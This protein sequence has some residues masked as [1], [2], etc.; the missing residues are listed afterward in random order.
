MLNKLRQAE[1]K[2]L[3]LEVSL[4]DPAIASDPARCAEI[5]KEYKNLTPI[6][7]KYREYQRAEESAKEAL[8]LLEE[9]S[10]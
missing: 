4:S 5:A 2:Y 10:N 9:N 8:E 7:E 3:H 1:E 6:I